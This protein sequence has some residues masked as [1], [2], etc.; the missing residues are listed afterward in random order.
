MAILSID[1]NI[2]SDGIRTYLDGLVDDKVTEYVDERDAK[3]IGYVSEAL[4][5]PLL[6]QMTLEQV[7]EFLI[8]EIL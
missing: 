8:E 2:D 7:V 5:K 1:I 4:G 6:K 3:L